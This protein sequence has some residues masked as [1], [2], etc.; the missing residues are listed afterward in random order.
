M[1]KSLA[2][3][4]AKA[5]ATALPIPLRLRRSRRS[6]FL[7]AWCPFPLLN[8]VASGGVDLRRSNLDERCYKR[9]ADALVRARD[10]GAFVFELEVH[11]PIAV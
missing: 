5:R 2:P 10:E 4:R 11:A 3:S 8:L 7:A 6:C 1:R 9:F